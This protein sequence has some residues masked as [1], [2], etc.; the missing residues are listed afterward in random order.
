MWVHLLLHLDY[1]YFTILQLAIYMFGK[2]FINIYISVQSITM[3]LMYVYIYLTNYLVNAL[4]VSHIQWY[5]WYTGWCYSC[6][7]TI[8]SRNRIKTFNVES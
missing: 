8:S 6:I 3:G 1:V 5:E 7:E 4:K 2:L